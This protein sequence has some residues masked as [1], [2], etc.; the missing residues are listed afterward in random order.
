MQVAM[1]S[2]SYAEQGRGGAPAFSAFDRLSPEAVVNS[3]KR[4]N[5]NAV[6]DGEPYVAAASFRDALEAERMA[7]ALAAYG[8]AEIE[9]TEID[10]VMWYGVNLRSDGRTSLDDLLRVAWSHGAPDAIAVRD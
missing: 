7:G 4:M 10:G 2:L 5:G 6:P 3:W 1:A 9:K 8:R